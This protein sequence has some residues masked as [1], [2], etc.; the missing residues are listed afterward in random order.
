MLTTQSAPPVRLA[1][2]PDRVDVW[3]IELDLP[4][5]RMAALW[6]ALSADERTRA[7]RFLFGRDRQRFAAARGQLREILAG[8]QGAPADQLA[9]GYGAHGKPFLLAPAGGPPAP[10]FNLAH[11][12]ERAICAVARGRRL[13]VDLEHIRAE[14]ALEPGATDCFAPG[15]RA[16]LAALPAAELPTAFFHTW[17]CKEAY[18]KATGSGLA[19]QLDQFDVST[20]PA[21]PARLLRVAGEPAERARWS[22]Q[23][24]P[25][26]RGY[27]AAL[28]A[29]G[30]GWKLQIG[31]WGA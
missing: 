30:A 6:R 2:A 5:R 26:G 11:S 16:A 20:D 17:V 25:A 9:F 15:E 4:E 1:L 27:A 3:W 24:L 8:Y 19:L 22:L 14:L 21:Q 31:D 23:A 13:G 12:G 18:L 28:A 7:E 29:E 10:S